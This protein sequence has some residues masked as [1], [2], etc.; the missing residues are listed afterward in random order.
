MPASLKLKTHLD[1]LHEANRKPE[2]ARNRVLHAYKFSAK[3]RQ[4]VFDLSDQV[5]DQLITRVCHYCGE[6]PSNVMNEEGYGLKYS[7]IDR[8]DSNISYTDENCVSC[9]STCN[10]MKGRLSRKEFLAKIKQIVDFSKPSK[11]F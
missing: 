6:P 1:R 7:G 10:D 3:R 8:L 2:A 4:L 11:F 9:C 5:F